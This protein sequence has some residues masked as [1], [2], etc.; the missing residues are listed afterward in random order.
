ML[1]LL[2]LFLPSMQIETAL[3]THRGEFLCPNCDARRPYERKV[4]QIK[5]DILFWP[6]V[7]WGP[8]TIRIHCLECRTSF[9]ETQLRGDLPGP[10][11]AAALRHALRRAALDFMR[12]GGRDP[13]ERHALQAAWLEVTGEPLAD[14]AID[15]E[16][17][18]AAG[19]PR[20][21]AESLASAAPHLRE[22]AKEGIL[23][24]AISAAIAGG[25]LTDDDRT[26]LRALGAALEMSAAHVRGVLDA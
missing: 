9:D 12:A 14:A 10:R 8:K 3:V 4:H 11:H 26:R 20:P 24:A 25:P 22:G 1:W 15:E 13:A 7:P 18:R 6:I 16:I 19:D 17:A 23:R 21:V 2:D 5:L